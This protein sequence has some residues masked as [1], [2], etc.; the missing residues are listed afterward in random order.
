MK[1]S[2]YLGLLFLLMAASALPMSA[3]TGHFDR[4]LQVSGPVDLEVT[5]GSGNINVHTGGNGS[6]IVSA[7]IHARDN[8]FGG[9][10]AEEKIKRIESNP[11]IEQSGNTIHIGRIED[12]DL[13]QNISIDYDVTVPA[14]TNVNSQ[15]GSGDQTI[16]GVQLPLTAKTGSGNIKIDNIGAG[17]HI[18]SGSGDLRI[19]SVKGALNA[20]AGSGNIEAEGI[21][22][23]IYANTGSGDVEL[24]QVAAGDVQ[25]QTGSGTVRIRG[26][27]GGLRV[28]TGSGDIH[29][30]GEPTHDWRVGAGSGNID[31]KI[32][33]GA[34]FD[35][36]AQTSSG[37]LNVNRQITMQGNF[38]RNHIEGKVGNGGVRLDLHTGSGNIELD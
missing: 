25:V 19:N 34:S 21:A 32:P 29:A 2:R 3:A 31:L 16:S 17:A 20:E 30:E 11:P 6:V 10:S 18:R 9:L 35:L 13:R 15:T 14:Q 12:R 38:S 24:H 22:G 5:S 23:E 1:I 36:S 33:S 27:K 26:V 8:W 7:K 28:Q 37:S 4:T